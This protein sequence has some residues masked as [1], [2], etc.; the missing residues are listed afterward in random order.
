MKLLIISRTP[1]NISN[2][3]GN[4]FSNLFGG[5]EDVEIYSI[6]CQSGS[7][8]NDIVKDT[9]QITESS[10]LSFRKLPQENTGEE[11][12]L[13]KEFQSVGKKKRY[14]WMFF[15]RDF[16]WKLNAFRWKNSVRAFIDKV[17]PDLL[18]L[19]IYPSL[20]MCEMGLYVANKLSVPV[21][22]HITD[23]V[24][25]YPTYC[26]RLSPAYFYRHLVRKKIRALVHRAA[27]L[28]VFAQNMKAVYEKELGKPCYLIGKGVR[29]E[30][31]CAP[32][33]LEKGKEELHFVYTGGV[34]GERLSA[35]L[36]LGRALS[37]KRCVLDIY[38]P[39][40]LS[41]SDRHSMQEVSPIVFHGFIGAVEVKKVQAE[42][43]VLV[44]VEGFSKKAA[45]ETGM[46][47]STKII[48]YLATGKP[49]LAIGPMSVNSIQV[50]AQKH[51]ALV[52][53]SREQLTLAV[54]QIVC[55]KP[56]VHEVQQ[57]AYQYLIEER[58]LENIQQGMYRRMKNLL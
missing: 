1:W 19:P 33:K 22:G 53:D 17:K 27:Y 34:G 26:P 29:P 44:H 41:E 37:G 45:F 48:D 49:L 7:V 36:M 54:E 5:M 40:V 8:H 43:D 18:Y 11:Q 23:D 39:T 10:L 51:I 14:V 9:L 25:R 58:N 47:F 16:I 6:C 50:L 13:V 35:L 57:N 55:D 31:V 15:A 20:Y 21:V 46:S 2:S 52:A 28:E 24:Y 3:F 56:V 4:T 32:G 12:S 38:S 42:A 30:E